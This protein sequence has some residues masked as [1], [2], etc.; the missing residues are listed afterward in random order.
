MKNKFWVLMTIAGIIIGLISCDTDPVFCPDTDNNGNG[1]LGI[2]ENCSK[3]TGDCTGLQNYN[4]STGVNAFPKPIYR[5]GKADNFAGTVLVDTADKII[6]EYGKLGEAGRGRINTSGLTYVQMHKDGKKY[7]WGGS[8]VLGVQAGAL[9]DIAYT[10]EDLGSSGGLPVQT[11]SLQPASDIRLAKGKKSTERFPAIAGC[12]DKD[13]KVNTV[14]RNFKL[15]RQAIARNNRK[16][17]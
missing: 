8:G 6:I 7:T 15:N 11:A 16:L 17:T 12:A 4:T 5:V 9:D 2:G 10:I 3:D 1:H 13:P 14:V